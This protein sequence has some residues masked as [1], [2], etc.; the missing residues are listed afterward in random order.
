MVYNSSCVYH[1]KRPGMSLTEGYIGVTNNLTHRLWRHNN[2]DYV[3]GRALRK[4]K[5]AYLQVLVYSTAEECFSLEAKLRPEPQTG[6]NIA[7][8]GGGYACNKGRK[9]TQEHKDKIGKA[10]NLTAQDKEVFNWKHKDGREEEM[11]M[12]ELR[13]KHNIIQS[14]ISSVKFF[15]DNDSTEDWDDSKEGM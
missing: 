11:T 3:V 10:N 14:N 12:Y 4:H 5:D 7:E 13:T 8:G 9:L 1:I 2:S 6:W 15:I